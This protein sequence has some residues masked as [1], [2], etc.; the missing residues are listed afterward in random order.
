MTQSQ[1]A[2]SALSVVP[3][4]ERLEPVRLVGADAAL[5]EQVVDLA[6]DVVEALVD[7]RLVEVGDD[8]R[9]LQAAH[10]QQRELA[11]P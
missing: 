5:L 4:D 2:K 6:A 8:D 1:S 11:W 9:H 10:E 3:R 7:A